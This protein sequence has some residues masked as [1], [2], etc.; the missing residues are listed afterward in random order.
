M[1]KHTTC[2]TYSRY[3]PDSIVIYYEDMSA[4]LVHVPLDWTLA[5]VCSSPG[6]ILKAGTPALILLVKDSK[7]HKDFLNKYSVVK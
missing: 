4:D 6:F 5:Q 2:A 3:T 7:A 1:N